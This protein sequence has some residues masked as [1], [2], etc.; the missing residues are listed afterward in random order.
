MAWSMTLNTVGTGAMAKPRSG[1]SRAVLEA[2]I[3]P[4]T[5]RRLPCS[6]VSN[7]I[8]GDG[9]QPSRDPPRRRIPMVLHRGGFPDGS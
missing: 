1:L 6:A 2:W 7:L 4:P 8:L 3:D 9:A 5:P